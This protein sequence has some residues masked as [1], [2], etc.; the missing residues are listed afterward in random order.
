VIALITIRCDLCRNRIDI[1]VG[2]TVLTIGDA[3]HRA[4]RKGWARREWDGLVHD[5]CPACGTGFE[6]I[7]E[8]QRRRRRGQFRRS[9]GHLAP[10]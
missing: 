5:L 2:D 7:M 4:Q 10:A 3:R 6:G 1:A 9:L 8:N